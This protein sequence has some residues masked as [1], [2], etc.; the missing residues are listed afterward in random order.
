MD[1]T[2]PNAM[3]FKEDSEFYLATFDAATSG[4]G[5]G[6]TAKAHQFHPITASDPP[7][8]TISLNTQSSSPRVG[9]PVQFFYRRA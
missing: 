4:E 2:S 9:T 1:T 6:D 8:G 5:V 7:R 3:S